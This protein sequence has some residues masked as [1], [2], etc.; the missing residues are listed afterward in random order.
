MNYPE[1]LIDLV[2]RMDEV[3]IEG[4]MS[5]SDALSLFTLSGGQ[6]VVAEIGSWKGCSTSIIAT[7]SGGI[8]HAIDTWKGSARTWLAEKARNEDVYKVFEDNMIRL[9]VWNHIRPMKMSSQEA[10]LKFEDESLDMV[11]LD[12]DHHYEAVKED[13]P[14]WLPKVKKGGILVGHDAEVFFSELSDND[15]KTIDG[16]L[17]ADYIFD[18]EHPKDGIHPGVVKALWECLGDEHTLMPKRIWCYK[19]WTN[20]G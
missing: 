7:A 6:A 2:G 1:V 16:F 19:K 20:N 10:V 4:Q 5:T 8:V 3:D 11:F 12:A 15:Q 9:G 14:V 13:I 17:G 18:E